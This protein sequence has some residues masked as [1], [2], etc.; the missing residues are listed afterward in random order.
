VS[1]TQSI[2]AYRY[3]GKKGLIIAALS[4]GL[5]LG[6]IYG[7]FHYAIDVLA[8]ALLGAFLTLVGLAASARLTPTRQANANAPT[9]P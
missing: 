6:A 1:V 5:A 4:V 8:G 2:L 3:F 7:G 9:Y